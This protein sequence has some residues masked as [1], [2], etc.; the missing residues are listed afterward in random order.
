MKVIEQVILAS[1]SPV[2]KNIIETLSLPFSVFPS[3]V[4]ESEITAD[5]PSQIA[6]ARAFEKAE[7]VA[8]QVSLALVVGCDQVLSFE[9]KI[10]SKPKN[11]EEAFCQL[12]SLQ[13]KEHTLFSAVSLF[14]SGSSPFEAVHLRSWVSPAVMAMKSLEKHEI[15]GYIATGEWE[16][17]VG[18]YKIE[19]A[20]ASLFSSFVSSFDK[21]IIMGL[22]KEEFVA[23][24]TK[25][26]CDFSKEQKL[27]FVLKL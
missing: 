26:G 24:V 8:K 15:E 3:N 7:G 22:P 11:E 19:G 12:E 5:T 9:D 23:E 18:G 4:K 1:K 14:Y 16:G 21:T 27:P 20:G 17:S 25:L 6:S 10:F 2:R 13:G